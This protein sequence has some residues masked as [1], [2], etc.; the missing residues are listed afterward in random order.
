MS[1]NS[2]ASWGELVEL[3]GSR[4]ELPD[5]AG[6][7]RDAPEGDLVTVTIVLRR[8]NEL[9][10]EGTQGP[11]RMGREE[12]A[13]RYGGDP[14]DIEQVAQF[15]LRND[16]RVVRAD[17]ASRRVWVEGTVAALQRA[18]G[19]R[20]QTVEGTALR[21]RKG[22]VM[23]P[24]G[25]LGIVSGV[26]GLD[27]RPQARPHIVVADD[28]AASGGESAQAGYTALDLAAL[29]N[30]PRG[31]N[32][33]GETIGILELGGG[34]W[35]TD[36]VTYFRDLGLGVPSL[37]DV[38]VNGA[39]NNPGHNRDHD[40]EVALDIAVAGG[41]APGA[42]LVVYFAP[43][44]DRG[45][46]DCVY[47]AVHDAVNELT[48]LTTS[49]GAAEA[50]HTSMYM[51]NVD[52]VL[53]D[54]AALGISVFAASGDNGSSDG[55]HDR[56]AHV[57]F[58]ASS[59]H[60]TGCGGTHLDSSDLVITNEYVWNNGHGGATGGGVSDQFT[61]PRWQEDLG[62][63]RSVNPHPGPDHGFGRGVPDVAGAAD[64]SPGFRIFVD[65]AYLT[66]GGT[67][68]VAPMWAGLA[69]LLNQALGRE[70][71]AL[72]PLIYRHRAG[73]SG[74]R[75]ITWGV[76]G[77]YSARRGWDACTGFGSPNGVD[78]L[79]ALC[80]LGWYLVGAGLLDDDHR[81][82]TGDFS[83]AGLTEFM[84]YFRS[85]GN[86]WRGTMD[87]GKLSWVLVGN[88]S[89]FGDL[90]DGRPFWTGDFSGV[91]RTQVIFY[92][93]G[94]KNWW[95]G[96]IRDGRLGW[97]LVGNT[98]QFGQVADGRPF[99]TGNFSGTG[100][101]QFMFYSPADDNWWLGTVSDG[102][103][104]WVLVG[105]TS[106]FGDLADGRPFW[107]GDF[108]G[109]GRTQVIF[110]FPGDKN[111]WLGTI[112]DGELGWELVG[113]TNQF[114]QVADGRPFWT[115]NFS[116]TGRTQFMF[117]SPADDNWWL[118]T[119]SDGK[120]DWVLVGNTSGFGD[121]ADGRPFWT[122]D[123]SGVGRTQVIF[124]FPGDKNWWLG[125]IRDGELGWE[126]VGNTNQFG[127]VADG[128]PFWTGNFSGTGRTQ[129]MFYSPADDNWWLGAI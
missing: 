82:W 64:D 30:F 81:F 63:P 31:V 73:L 66:T 11:E 70:I 45:Y 36:L 127:Q 28:L 33:R 19:V 84:C 101:T 111:W 10:A 112:R 126:L 96:T 44:D 65:G 42:K 43:P 94:D 67:S 85:D 92:F 27:N 48:V 21:L 95:L 40:Q 123:F 69:A 2:I 93:P 76:N 78:L 79:A 20:L 62:V 4:R 83:G 38:S 119:V 7:L 32:G 115:G 54:A 75:D 105:N 97:E 107:T 58:P 9:P 17:A 91:G 61:L 37:T 13:A 108:S 90:A 53:T 1:E 121:L 125:T 72:N 129:F 87:K 8:R 47:N 55:V 50:H 22:P 120:L 35:P 109:V 15:T 52:A 117:Y 114:G 49:W 39:T 88:T 113:N 41:C 100:R 128:R 74:F 106:G 16:L 60:A 110:Y 122:G 14:A 24:A 51:L 103:L 5:D 124:Y 71:G 68:G 29:Y 116:G 23:I 118:G 98:N 99:W 46:L 89:G 26:F 25:L 6:A 86:W 102:K 57:D 3:P 77:A 104:D 80:P 18:F 34:Y 59:P 56:A 12:F